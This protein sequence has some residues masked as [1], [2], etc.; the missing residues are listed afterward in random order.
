MHAQP[1]ARGEKMNKELSKQLAEV[2]LGCKVGNHLPAS[3]CQQ[4][5]Y[6]NENCP[7]IEG[8]KR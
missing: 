3:I 5:V 8:E 2:L 6:N 1:E 7:A 4:C